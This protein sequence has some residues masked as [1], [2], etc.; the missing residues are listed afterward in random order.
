MAVR[1]MR[2][3]LGVFFLFAGV[4]L[5]VLRFGMPDAAARLDPLRLFLGAILALVFSAVNLMK[6]YA[7]WLWFHQQATPVR[8]P[9]QPESDATTDREYLP[10]FDFTKPD[11][12][13][14]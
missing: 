4:G 8:R 3:I 13:S 5:L 1:H 7:G 9:L 2:L 12:R 10:E 6:W 14:K 11:E